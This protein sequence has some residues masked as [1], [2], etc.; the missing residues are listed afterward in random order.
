MIAVS[1]WTCGGFA[2]PNVCSASRQ[3]EVASPGSGRQRQL[4]DSL[5]I[6]TE[7]YTRDTHTITVYELQLVSP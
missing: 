5:Q 6:Y 4:T 2:A 3:E 7:T 1:C